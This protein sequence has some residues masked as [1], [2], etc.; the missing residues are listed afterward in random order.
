MMPN[1]GQKTPIA[2]TLEQFGHRKAQ[3][4]I[5][6]LGQSLP[7]S[8][9]TVVSSGIVTVKFELTNVPF[10]LQNITVPMIGSE[11]VRL[12]IQPGCKGL[13]IAADAYLGGMSG[14]GGGTADLTHRPNLSNLA[15]VPL[16]NKGWSA[17]DDANAVVIYGPDGA[18]IRT[19]AKDATLTIKTGQVTIQAASVTAA[20][21][22]GTPQPVKLADGSVSTVFK[23]Q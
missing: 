14:L 4:A 18:I 20:A 5:N 10:T 12:P 11:Y 1:T 7:A 9:A 6:L 2:R 17:P 13:V 3:S 16:G 23:A 22:A 19:L 15:F 8:V 21:S